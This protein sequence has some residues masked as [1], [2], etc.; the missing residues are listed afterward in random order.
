MGQKVRPTG[1]RIGITED[2]RSRWY[3][4]KK[5]FGRF[6][7][8]DQKLRNFIKKNYHF[9]GISRIEIERSG[10]KHRGAEVLVR[11]WTARPGLMIGK[12]GAS[13][14][15][16]EDALEKL[17]GSKV[18]ADVREVINPELDATLLA[19]YIAEQLVK[20]TAFRRAIKRAIEMAVS[21]GAK[22]VKVAVAG[23]LGGAEMARREGSHVGSIPLHTLRAIIDYGFTE[24]FTKSGAI[25][26][27]VWIYKGQVLSEDEVRKYGADAKTSQVSSDA[28]RKSARQS[29]SREPG[30]FRRVRAYVARMRL[31][32]RPA[33]RGRP[34]RGPALPGAG[35]EALEA[36]I[37]S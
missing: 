12:K 11:I 18:H 5:D 25:G 34:Y 3:A 21:K 7:V 24:A 19:N 26:I 16:L 31:D 23:R 6:L 15:R 30:F 29:D 28:A 13:L 17:T 36:R 20:R 14:Q 1:L 8:E 32:I 27:K 2:W 4:R 33:D 22:G 37:P 9:A 35:R 10:A